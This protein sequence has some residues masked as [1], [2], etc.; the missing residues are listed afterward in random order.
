MGKN[1]ITTSNNNDLINEARKKKKRRKIVIF[2]AVTMVVVGAFFFITNGKRNAK[3]IVQVKTGKVQK[4]DIESYFATTANIQSNYV[5]KYYAPSNAKVEKVA[6]SVGDEVKAGQILV[7]YEAQDYSSSIAQNQIQYEN[8]VISKQDLVDQNKDAQKKVDGFNSDIKALNAQ[9][10]DLQAQLDELNNTNE[11]GS[12]NIQINELNVQMTSLNTQVESLEKQRDS[13]MF[14]SDSR[15]KQADNSIK[16][17]K[18]SLDNVKEQRDKAV[19]TIVAE[20]DGVI[21]LVNSVEGAMD[22]V[23]QPSIEIM[24]VKD[25]KAI[26]Y[27]NKYEASSIEI[28]DRAIIDNGNKEYNGEITFI[29][30]SAEKGTST[31]KLEVLITDEDENLK[32]NFDTD[33]DILTDTATDV[34]SIPVEAIKTDKTGREYVFV[35]MDNK[36]VE[37]DVTIGV[38][39]D[40]SAEVIEGLSI[41]EE[42]ILNPSTEIVNGT[43]VTTDLTN[44][45]K[46]KSLFGNMGKRPGVDKNGDS[47]GGE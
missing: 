29:A 6:F 4:G 42:V 19:N 44:I 31:L 34:M 3:G 30:P 9:I 36:A 25:L 14:I 15:I 28:G 38:Q 22:N 5:K 12:K 17:A 21:T 16:L 41:D 47:I 32:I 43:M 24:D 8:A 45:K 27:V 18:I 37:K 26:V 10:E 1:E 11:D 40:D 13:V 20:K 23:A 33:V 35:L 46:G 2:S 7:T 39:S